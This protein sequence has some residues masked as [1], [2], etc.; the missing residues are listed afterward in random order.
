MLLYTTHIFFFIFKLS[1]SKQVTH[2]LDILKN[3]QENP[4]DWC[5]LDN[6]SAI[7]WAPSVDDVIEDEFNDVAVSSGLVTNPCSFSNNYQ[8]HHLNGGF[9]PPNGVPN[10]FKVVKPETNKRNDDYYFIENKALLNKTFKSDYNRT[11]SDDQTNKEE[12]T[13]FLRK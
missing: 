12:T 5:N 8:S 2:L 4:S 11:K 9:K 7:V 10:G 1:F 6:Q 3:T 13:S